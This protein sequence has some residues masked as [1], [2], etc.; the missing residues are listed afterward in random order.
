MT[1]KF[2]FIPSLL[3]TG[4]IIAHPAFAQ[5]VTSGSSVTQIETFIKSIVSV[6]VTLA[7]S[8]AV[9][10]FVI[11]GFRYITSTGNPESLE[12]AKHTIIYSGIGLTIAL[13]AFV[14]MNII[15]QLATSAFGAAQ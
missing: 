2:A 8:V 11:G 13:G 10:F 6:L 14:L 3:L 4:L 5:A 9:V 12:K 7:G 15:S 1:K